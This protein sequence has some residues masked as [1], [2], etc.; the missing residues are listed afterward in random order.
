VGLP[1]PPAELAVGPYRRSFSAVCGAAA[2]LPKLRG[3]PDAGTEEGLHTWGTT[4]LR[5]AHRGLFAIE[6]ELDGV[7]QNE[8]RSKV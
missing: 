8:G 7:K 6:C 4:S 2:C 3:H 5:S 1:G